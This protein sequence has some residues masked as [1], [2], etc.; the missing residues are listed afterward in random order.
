[1]DPAGPLDIRP[2]SLTK[3]SEN[4]THPLNFRDAIVLVL[5]LKSL[6]PLCGIGS[7]AP[8]D[9]EMIALIITIQIVV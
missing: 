1:L 5:S 6:P 4:L 2:P 8:M 7:V 9:R 3:I